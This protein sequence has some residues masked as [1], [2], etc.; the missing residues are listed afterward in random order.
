MNIIENAQLQYMCLLRF[1]VHGLK[2]R[3]DYV[4]RVKCVSRAGNSSYSDESQPIMVKSA[5]RKHAC[6]TK[7]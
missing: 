3:K 1:T 7:T 4:F 6:Q 2:T 5:I